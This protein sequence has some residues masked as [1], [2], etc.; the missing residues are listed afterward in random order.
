M[1]KWHPVYVGFKQLNRKLENPYES[2]LH[3]HK[4]IQE[5]TSDRYKLK[6]RFC[7]IEDSSPG[8][9]WDM[10]NDLWV[11]KLKNANDAMRF[12]LQYADVLIDPVPIAA[13]KPKDLRNE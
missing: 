3:L 10:D 12:K 13:K 5:T 7:W 9:L 2:N 4:M 1:A 11:V 6:L 8:I